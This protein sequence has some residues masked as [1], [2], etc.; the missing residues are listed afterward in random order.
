MRHPFGQASEVIDK[1]PVEVAADQICAPYDAK[2]TDGAPSVV[3]V[4]TK[5]MQHEE[6]LQAAAVVDTWFQ[7]QVILT[8]LRR[9]VTV[10][11]DL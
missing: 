9:M 2:L 10:E 4:F 8:R 3:Q 11:A 5:R 1:V 6:C 7:L